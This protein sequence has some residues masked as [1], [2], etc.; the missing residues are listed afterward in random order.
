MALEESI[1]T[2]PP[3]FALAIVV[4]IFYLV[5]TLI[6][7]WQTFIKYRSWFFLC[8][9]IGS[10]IE[11]AGY[12]VRA[13][14]IKH[15]REIPPFAVSSTLIIIAPVFVAAGNYL[16]IGRL[17]RAVLSSDKHRI[18]FIPARFITK[19][20]VSFDILAFLIQASGSGI[21]S[22]GSWEGSEATIGTNVLIGGLAFQVATFT[23]FLSIVLRFWQHTKYHIRADAPVGWSRVLQAIWVSS[24]L[25]LVRS[26]YR[27][28][29]FALGIDGYP[30][31]HEWIFYVFESLPMLPAIAIFCFIH[32]AKYLGSD[33]GLGK[34]TRVE[35]GEIE[36]VE[37][38]HR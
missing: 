9:L 23:W 18:F 2:Y 32:P 3:S 27:V 4:A 17:I 38:S 29:E 13:V 28:V 11:V 12:I 22:S 35:E 37:A 15:D 16:L 7:C 6:L 14:S 26:V 31:E 21:A 19:I 24:S 25:I 30:F 36:L 20:F 33:G 1:W 8:V 10:A 34:Q 5:P